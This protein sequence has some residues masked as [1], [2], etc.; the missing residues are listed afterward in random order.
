MRSFG[1]AICTHY[2]TL[3]YFSVYFITIIIIYQISNGILF[4]VEM[5]KLHNIIWIF[6][7]TI[8][9]RLIFF[10]SDVLTNAFFSYK[11]VINILLF[12]FEVMPSTTQKAPW[13]ILIFIGHTLIVDINY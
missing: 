7:A 13:I 11:C 12:I 6:Y 3:G 9:T 4:V 2:L 10:T 5:V 1:V 8:Y